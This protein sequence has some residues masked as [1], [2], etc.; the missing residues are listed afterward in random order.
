MFTAII[1]GHLFGDYM[2]QSKKMAIAKSE[3]SVT[4]L[5]WCALHCTIYTLAICVFT[6]QFQWWFVALVFASHF[7]IDRWSLGS[8]WL[9]FIGGRDFV[10]AYDSNAKYREIDIAFSCFVYAIV[11]NTMHIT[12][13]WLIA[14]AAT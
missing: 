12:L 3:R 4:G 13:L 6:G 7:P 5:L 1:L 8:K 9:R 11:D 2:L 10:T 14:K